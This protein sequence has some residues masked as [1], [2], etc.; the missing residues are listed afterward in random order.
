MYS[1][2][3]TS[4]REKDVEVRVASNE[5]DVVS[6]GQ[7]GD[8]LFSFFNGLTAVLGTDVRLNKQLTWEL[9]S[10]RVHERNV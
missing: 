4:D 10:R 3:K 1:I 6:T 2:Q 5:T 9:S 7:L 8:T